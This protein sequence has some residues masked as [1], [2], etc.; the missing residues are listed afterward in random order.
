MDD[1]DSSLT[2]KRPRL[3]SGD[4]S[5]R[6]M[7][8]DELSTTPPHLTMNHSP[9]ATASPGHRDTSAGVN[10]TVST[11]SQTPSKV[12]INVRDSGP[13]VSQQLP[14][15][16]DRMIENVQQD[17]EKSRV[18]LVEAPANGQTPSPDV[19]SVSSS[20]SRSPEI[21]VA[22]VEDMEDL[23][24]ETRWRTLREA[25]NVQITILEHF[26]YHSPGRHYWRS[27]EV[28]A[29]YFENGKLNNLHFRNIHC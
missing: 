2:R 25:T 24:E 10:E 17:S 8:A 9:S 16:T 7:S 18:E 4:R 13:G 11:P 22:E 23:P 6:S 29:D 21:E 15:V 14:P 19:I 27:A 5:H 28:V 26:P 1:S 3:Y 20:S 12:T